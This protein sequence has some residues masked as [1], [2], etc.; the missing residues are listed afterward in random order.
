MDPI[1]LVEP[2][3]VVFVDTFIGLSYCFDDHKLTKNGF[4]CSDGCGS[5]F[6]DHQY[7]L[8]DNLTGRSYFFEGKAL[9]I[10]GMTANVTPTLIATGI[11]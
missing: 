5:C 4:V 3:S 11:K 10:N 1:V 8:F 7:L 9:L 2:S 6:G